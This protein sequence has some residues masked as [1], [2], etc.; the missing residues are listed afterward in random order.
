MPRHY[1]VA[2]NYHE[3]SS[4][5]SALD[6]TFM[7]DHNNPTDLHET[8]IAQSFRSQNDRQSQRSVGYTPQASPAPIS[9]QSHSHNPA[10]DLQ[11]EKHAIENQMITLFNL[12]HRH[13]LTETVTEATF[14]YQNL[15]VDSAH[16]FLVHLQD[17]VALDLSFNKLV[18][19]PHPL[20]H[21]LIGLDLSANFITSLT[22]FKKGWPKCLV[23]L[24]LRNN[25]IT[26]TAGLSHALSLEYLDLSNNQI[27]RV[28]GLEPLQHLRALFLKG[29]K[30]ELEIG[31]RPLSF[32]KA[33]TELDLRHNPICELPAYRNIVSNFVPNLSRLD[34]VD[35]LNRSLPGHSKSYKKIYEE[36]KSHVVKG[37]DSRHSP[38]S[39][40]EHRVG[41][42]SPTL[43]HFHAQQQQQHQR[44]QQQQ[45][46]KQQH[47]NRQHQSHRVSPDNK[48]VDTRNASDDDDDSS[49]PKSALP[50]RNPPSPMPRPFKGVHYGNYHTTHHHASP[51]DSSVNSSHNYWKG[52]VNSSEKKKSSSTSQ[53][54]TPLLAKKTAEEKQIESHLGIQT[55]ELRNF[56]DS[57]GRSMAHPHSLAL[58]HAHAHSN[59]SPLLTPQNR[60]QPQPQSHSHSH[61]HPE[62]NALSDHPSG[63]RYEATTESGVGSYQQI[64]EQQMR[65]QQQTQRQQSSELK[66]QESNPY[67]KLSFATKSSLSRIWSD[68]NNDLDDEGEG[69]EIFQS[70]YE[71]DKTFSYEFYK[72]SQQQQQHTQHDVKTPKNLFT[73]GNSTTN[74]HH[75]QYIAT[76][77]S[78]ERIAHESPAG[79]NTK[80]NVS[81][82]QEK[83]RASDKERVGAVAED[84]QKNNQLKLTRALEIRKAHNQVK[85]RLQKEKEEA[86]RMKLGA[87][88]AG[89]KVSAAK[90]NARTAARQSVK[91]IT[92][93]PLSESPPPPPPPTQSPPPSPLQVTPKKLESE[94]A[95]ANESPASSPLDKGNDGLPESPST[96][97]SAPT[98]TSTS[99]PIST[100]ST[101]LG[102][103]LQTKIRLL[104]EAKKETL[105]VLQA[106]R[107][108]TSI[109]KSNNET[110]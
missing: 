84:D 15:T 52:T 89:K 24:K 46:Q 44:Q 76:S 17:M 98:S 4:Q 31:I 70:T 26:S 100:S 62:S 12:A 41:K 108:Q 18:D 75:P 95:S 93:L 103:E 8:S 74:P 91:P 78:S 20:P 63:Y 92:D 1:P 7:S 13:E 69:D 6:N 73:H 65:Q 86:E 34:A 11:R 38:H 14:R 3:T 9:Y 53:W 33:L 43:Y 59:S 79:M 40:D 72:Q 23:E 109:A 25:K 27:T 21:G 56:Q 105:R 83:Q 88:N 30:I 97:T 45:Q 36:I 2:A 48:S 85:I 106:A 67:P 101:M 28:E 37:K 81:V 68:E 55:L 104:I 99:T 82:P 16:T 49:A 54:C 110:K 61:L 90:A 51:S 22:H 50:W 5:I 19:M 87:S 35:C 107:N 66:Q 80:S 39:H 10:S 42:G 96:S 77:A 102:E 47:G 58:A 29:N 60:S 32:N 94:P 57:F 71:E 64:H